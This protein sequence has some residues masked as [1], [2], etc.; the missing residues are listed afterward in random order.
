MSEMAEILLQISNF[1]FSASATRQLKFV[2][3]G[4][5]LGTNCLRP[6]LQVG[7]PP[8]QAPAAQLEA[9]QPAAQPATQPAAQPTTQ[10]ATQP[11]LR[12]EE[13][14]AAPRQPQQPQHAGPALQLLQAQKPAAHPPPKKMPWQS[15]SAWPY[16]WRPQQQPPK[17]PWWSVLF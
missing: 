9:T 6:L 11:A 3:H 15:W 14:A 12:A 10:P 5:V 13:P 4:D 1:K 7:A 17:P 8:Q 16:F 2:S